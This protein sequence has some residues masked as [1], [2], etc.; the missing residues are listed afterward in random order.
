MPL[1]R[2]STS[3]T[4]KVSRSRIARAAAP[5]AATARSCAGARGTVPSAPP[6][7]AEH[8]VEGQSLQDRERV[9]ATRCDGDIVTGLAQD[10]RDHGP[11]RWLVVDRQH[12]PAEWSRAGERRLRRDR[13][14]RYG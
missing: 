5:V 6:V 7:V 9:G 3:I 13:C 8:P 11:D 12:D 10:P 14:G 4:S 2:W 1:I